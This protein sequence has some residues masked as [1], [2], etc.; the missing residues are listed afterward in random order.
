MI[1][2]VYMIA[3]RQDLSSSAFQTM[4]S[5]L[6]AKLATQLAATLGARRYGM[7]KRLER[8]CNTCVTKGRSLS[9]SPYHGVIEIWWDSLEAYQAGAGSAQGLV[10]IDQLIDAERRFV[11]FSKSAAFFAEEDVVFDHAKPGSKTAKKAA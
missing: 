4:W 11:D 10:A 1:K 9:E 6:H 5:E 3:K 8:V 7:T 2:L